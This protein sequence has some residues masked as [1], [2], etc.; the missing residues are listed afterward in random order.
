MDHLMETDA[1]GPDIA[2]VLKTLLSE[3]FVSWVEILSFAKK[4]QGLV[5]LQK[6]LQ[7]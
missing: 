7:V 6:K 4:Y 5:K 3:R 1:P 2:D